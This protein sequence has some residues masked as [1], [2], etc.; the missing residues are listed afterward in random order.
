MKAAGISQKTSYSRRWSSRILN[1]ASNSWQQQLSNSSSYLVNL[2]SI[3]L[4]FSTFLFAQGSFK[5]WLPGTGFYLYPTE[6]LSRNKLGNQVDSGALLVWIY[7]VPWAL[8]TTVW[9][10]EQTVTRQ[11]IYWNKLKRTLQCYI[12]LYYLI[13]LHVFVKWLLVCLKIQRPVAE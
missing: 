1:L 12:H 4:Y 6:L 3:L 2:S 11:L 8:E 9:N 13:Y 10:C 7:Y 5:V